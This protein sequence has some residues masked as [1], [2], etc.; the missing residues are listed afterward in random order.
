MISKRTEAQI[1][2][3]MNILDVVKCFLSLKKRGTNYWA[4][5]PF[6]D[7]KTP[8]F[9]VNPG[10]GI[11]K[12]FSSGH[13]GDAISFLK[14]SQG[15]TYR[16]ALE[17]LA[18]HYNI[19]I[20]EQQLTQ[21]QRHQ[22]DTKADMATI[23][24]FAT[25]YYQ[26]MLSVSKST[27]FQDRGFTAETIEKYQLGW[28]IAN[29]D[30][31]LTKATG[32]YN[33]ELMIE[34]GLLGKSEKSGNLYDRLRSRAIFPIKNLYGQVVA[35]GARKMDKDEDQPAKYI[36]SSESLLYKKSKELYGIYEAKQA[37]RNEGEAILT[38][39]YTDVLAM[40]QAGFEH[41][42]GSCGTALTV[43][44]IRLI[45]RFTNVVTL[46]LDG[47]A[48]GIKAAMKAIPLL[49]SEGMQVKVAILP[50]N[51]DPDS[52]LKAFGYKEMFAQLADA[53]DGIFWWT[54]LQDIS[55]TG[56]L[57][58]TVRELTSLLKQLPF[59]LDREIYAQQASTWLNVPEDTILTELGHKEK[60]I[61]AVSAKEM[62][63]FPNDWTSYINFIKRTGFPENPDFERAA[64]NGVKVHF[65]DPNNTPVNI[66]SKKDQEIPATWI[67]TSGGLPPHVVYMPPGLRKYLKQE[68]RAEGLPLFLAEDPLTAYWLDCIGLCAVGLLQP[69]GFVASKNSKKLNPLIK[70]CVSMGFKRVVYLAPGEMFQLPPVG[71]KASTNPY[72]MRDAG[73]IAYKYAST[74]LRLKEAFGDTMVHLMH[75]KHQQPEVPADMDRWVE[76]MVETTAM[77][78]T[79]EDPDKYTT[80]PLYQALADEFS[81]AVHPSYQSALLE[82]WDISDMTKTGFEKVVHV[83]LAQDFFNFHGIESLGDCFQLGKYLYQA[84]RDNTVTV[85]DVSADR[86]AVYEEDGR[87]WAHT[88]SGSKPISNFTIKPHLKILGREP[89]ILG[90]LHQDRFEYDA[91]LDSEILLSSDKLHILAVG[92]GDMVWKGSNGQWREVQEMIFRALPAARLV[93]RLG[94]ME[95]S[96]KSSVFVYGDGIIQQNGTFQ[97]V[98]SQGLVSVHDHTLYLPAKSSYELGKDH[99]ANYDFHNKFEYQHSDVDWISYQHQFFKTHGPSAHPA[100]AYTIATV[101]RDIAFKQKKKFPLFCLLAPSGRGKSTL[102]SS[103]KAL[104]GGVLPDTNL[105]NSPTKASIGSHPRQISNAPCIIK[106]FNVHK[107]VQKGDKWAVDMAK[108]WYDGMSRATRRSAHNEFINN[109][110]ILSGVIFEAQ[111]DFYQYDEAVNNRFVIEEMPERKLDPIALN[112]IQLM[113]AR[114]LCHFLSEWIT[115]RPLI[116]EKYQAE[117]LEIEMELR[118]RTAK[119]KVLARIVENWAML[120][121][122]LMILIKSGKIEYPMSIK[123]IL[124]N[125]AEHII[126]HV[127]KAV[128]KGIISEFWD[129]I[130]TM[131][132]KNGWLDDRNVFFF[133]KENEIRIHFPS[134]YQLFKKFINQS[135]DKSITIPSKSELE[136]RLMQPEN[137]YKAKMEGAAM[138]YRRINILGSDRIL[139]KDIGNKRVPQLGKRTALCFDNAIL[140]LELPEIN[141][142]DDTELAQFDPKH[143]ANGKAHQ[144]ALSL[145]APMSEPTT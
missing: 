71:S 21:E 130:I 10:K 6:V 22:Q 120:I 57:A 62:A 144:T 8:S 69:E 141:Y 119:T 98:D 39:G 78:G 111:F 38:E 100:L 95:L 89:Y 7:E 31:L 101:Y 23:M 5:S 116:Q 41:T 105:E 55:T 77:M 17:W 32:A 82:R 93:D 114:G 3:R 92:K 85:V 137:G 11:F 64:D 4:L 68:D 70:L 61:P 51:H 99:A 28:A 121:T 20:S 75:P 117:Q 26:K 103:I 1:K 52:Y 19:E 42:V 59:D 110:P 87:Y 44:Q 58:T 138:G 13:G 123:Q 63:S 84:D 25:E 118:K 16:E 102:V 33:I 139:T 54:Q 128:S 136:K 14:E 135:G 126:D 15:Y 9:A 48:A 108:G 81:W 65:Y 104:F 2:E 143:Q 18:D 115:Y 124:D 94:W 45:R 129:F 43:E 80:S 131:Y 60:L 145:S 24:S 96:K 30:D 53:K 122:P 47:D 140:K 50:D 29:W 76:Y 79:V 72:S 46:L 40:Q 27:Y 35:F 36:N 91:V 86:L 142:E 49:I 12:C 132:G 90:T 109:K 74:M 106:E 73:A 37:I 97:P 112:D 127:K 125:A 133:D 34:M 83:H 67:T 88:K 113:E 134:T 66:S 56:A 107:L